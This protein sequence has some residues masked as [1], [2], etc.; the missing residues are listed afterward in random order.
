MLYE[1]GTA[2]VSTRAIHG[3]RP[4]ARAL[5]ARGFISNEVRVSPS[6]QQLL[7]IPIPT[8]NDLYSL[9]PKGL[10]HARRIRTINRLGAQPTLKRNHR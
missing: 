4:V 2:M 1:A 3:G 7:D 6:G 9:T 5:A 8:H 10:E